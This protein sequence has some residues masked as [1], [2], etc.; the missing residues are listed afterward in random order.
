MFKMKYYHIDDSEAEQEEANEF[1]EK[2]NLY[3]RAIMIF[4]ACTLVIA[5]W[6]FYTKYKASEDQKKEIEQMKK[7]G[8]GVNTPSATSRNNIDSLKNI[9]NST[10][11]N[12]E[13]GLANTN[14]T[15]AQTAQINEVNL[16]KTEIKDILN[17]ANYTPTDLGIA[18][19]KI[20][21]LQIKVNILQDKYTGVESE[22]RR[23]QAQIAALLQK[24][25]GSAAQKYST[26]TD[27]NAMAKTE[28]ATYQNENKQTL[29][30]GIQLFAVG[31]NGQTSSIDDAE[32]LVGSFV[33]SN[34]SKTAGE[35][36]I[37]VTQ[38]DGKVVKNSVWE[39]GSFDTKE[40]KKLYS[41]KMYIDG[42]AEEKQI[43]FSLTP[44]NFISGNY[45]VQVWQN[46]KLLA[47]KIKKI[48]L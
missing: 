35:V 48:G 3:T 45:T 31:D 46:G 21:Q 4:L 28:T 14:P 44:E 32:K 30:D 7:E 9:Y 42:T 15:A 2:Y 22:N 34:K 19:L 23:L 11:T 12:F 38:P 20:E 27:E 24:P 47:N 36:M 13:T 37:V 16:L 1:Q 10:V 18:K 17:K 29:I 26:G 6:V 33:C 8:I 43:N 40:G 5:V 39:S 41:R 25:N